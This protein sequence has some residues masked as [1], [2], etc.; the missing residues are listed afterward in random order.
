MYTI[1]EALATRKRRKLKFKTPFTV[2]LAN[3]NLKVLYGVKVDKKG[4]DIFIFRDGSHSDTQ[5]NSDSYTEVVNT[6]FNQTLRKTKN[7]S[8]FK[9]KLIRF[10]M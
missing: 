4:N 10:L 1:K 9:Y 5:L 6:I 3:N 8:R 7:E 2:K